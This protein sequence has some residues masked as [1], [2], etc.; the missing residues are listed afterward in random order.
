MQWRMNRFLRKVKRHKFV[1]R[2]DKGLF[3]FSLRFPY[4]KAGAFLV[5]MLFDDLTYYSCQRSSDL[6][7]ECAIKW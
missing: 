1:S 2:K 7:G 3:F 5:A 6:T 4:M